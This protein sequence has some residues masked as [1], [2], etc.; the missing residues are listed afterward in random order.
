MQTAAE[1]TAHYGEAMGLEL[2]E[3][4]F[5]TQADE[6]QKNRVVLISDVVAAQL[7]P[8]QSALGKTINL[9]DFGEGPM[10]VSYTHL[11]LYPR[12]VLVEELELAVAKAEHNLQGQENALLGEL[13]SSLQALTSAQRQVGLLGELLAAAEEDLELRRRQQAAGLVTDLQVAEA[14]LAAE[15]ARFDYFHAQLDMSLI[16]I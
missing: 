12:D 3:G 10:A 9:G 8:G 7:F 6:E 2:V 5:F 4:H 13:R 15:K 1:T 11:A 14:A 16:H